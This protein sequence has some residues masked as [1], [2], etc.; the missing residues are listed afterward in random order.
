MGSRRLVVAADG[1]VILP[2]RVSG[3]TPSVLMP[4]RGEWIENRNHASVFSSIGGGAYF[5]EAVDSSPDDTV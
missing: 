2:H 4:R 1:D 5:V 3:W